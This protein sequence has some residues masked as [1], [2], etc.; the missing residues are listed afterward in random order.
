[1]GGDPVGPRVRRLAPEDADMAQVLLHDSHAWNLAH[2]FNFWAATATAHEVRA[3]LA[4]HLALGVER[5]G[6]LVGMVVLRRAGE[7]FHLNNLAVAPDARGRGLAKQL[8]A[9]AEAAA[10]AE[11]AQEIELDTPAT[12]PWLPAYY[13]SLGYEPTGHVQFVGRNY[14]SVLMRRRLGP[15]CGD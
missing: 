7:E 10:I 11:G 15:A 13:A 2:G 6:R 9:A 5:D 14:R 4:A 3:V 12:H 8:I 1:M